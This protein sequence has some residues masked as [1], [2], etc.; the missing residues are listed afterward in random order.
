MQQLPREIEERREPRHPVLLPGEVRQATGR[1]SAVLGDISA[2]GCCI[3]GYTGCV[4]LNAPIHIRPRGLEP[5]LAWVRWVRGDEI[6]CEFTRAL[7]GPVLDYLVA[8]HGIPV[9]LESRAA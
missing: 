3:T 8:R 9:E 2:H 4:S 7:Y 1:T 5:M 6:G